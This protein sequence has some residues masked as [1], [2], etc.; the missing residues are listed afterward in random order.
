MRF[1][2]IGAGKVGVTLG[3]Y[4]SSSDKCSLAGYYSRSMTSAKEAASYTNSVC[5]D[6]AEQLIK[7]SDAIFLTVPDGQIASVYEEIC[8]YD[9]S[10]KQIIHCSGSLSSNLFS[11]V[12]THG[13]QGLSIHPLY[14]F[15]QPF[16]DNDKLSQAVFTIEG[17]REGFD[18]WKEVLEEFGNTV[19]KLSPEMKTKYHCAAVLS[20]NLILGLLD[21]GITLLEE[22]GFSTEE[23]LLAVQP[24]TMGNLEKAFSTS[25]AQA[26]TGPIERGDSST[27][28]K[29]FQVMDE[30]TLALYKLLS[31][32]ALKLAKEKNEDRNYKNVEEIL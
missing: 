1:A 10:G 4:L 14:A 23:A 3:K 32:R 29:H 9:I 17:C 8:H 18:F 11:H 7:E 28:E 2:F 13:A 30:E 24:L 6:N 21:C 25:P 12:E 27:L 26:L 31:K 16:G 15:S 22:C 5:F 19:V 20:S